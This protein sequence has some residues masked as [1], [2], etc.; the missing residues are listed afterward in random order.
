[1]TDYLLKN[2]HFLCSY[3]FEIK[4]FFSDKDKTYTHTHKGNIRDKVDHGLRTYKKIQKINLLSS[5]DLPIV[6]SLGNSFFL[7]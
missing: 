5:D 3:I 2:I 7:E 4:F 6:S 1:M